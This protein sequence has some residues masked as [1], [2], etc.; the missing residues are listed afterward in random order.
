MDREKQIE[1]G[2][3]NRT[4]TAWTLPYMSLVVDNWRSLSSLDHNLHLLGKYLLKCTELK[5]SMI[6]QAWK[7]WATDE[8]L[9]R[10]DEDKEK[11]IK[12]WDLLKKELAETLARVSKK[13]VALSKMTLEKKKVQ[14]KLDDALAILNSPPR[15]PP[16]LA[17]TIKS[18]SQSLSGMRAFLDPHIEEVTEDTLRTDASSLR[19]GGIYK[20]KVDLG[21]MMFIPNPDLRAEYV[22][23]PPTSAAEEKIEEQLDSWKPGMLKGA[24][25]HSEAFAPSRSKSGK[26]ILDWIVGTLKSQWTRLGMSCDEEKLRRLV[27]GDGIGLE[28]EESVALLRDVFLEVA[29][30]HP[31]MSDKDFLQFLDSYGDIDDNSS[32][33][34]MEDDVYVKF[35]DDNP[36]VHECNAIIDAATKV[37]SASGSEGR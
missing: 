8:R 35:H 10:A 5:P 19:L 7:K 31:K 13:S 14:K 30:G 36:H 27:D 20:W 33:E 17:K 37:A 28:G 1:N 34:S 26:V 25:E 3:L 29:K 11:V 23:P 12:A 18:F 32:V 21:D 2:V 24:E 22:N 16:T 6:F 15:Q 9:N 4:C